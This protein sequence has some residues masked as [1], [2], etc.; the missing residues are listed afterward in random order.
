[1]L[2]HAKDFCKY[3]YDADDHPSS[4]DAD[5][6]PSRYDADDHPSSYDADDHPSSCL[7]HADDQHQ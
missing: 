3:H 1:M 4:Y 7:Q 6:H 2:I 5:D